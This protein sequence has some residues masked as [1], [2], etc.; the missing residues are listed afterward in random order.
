[1]LPDKVVWFVGVDVEFVLSCR[2]DP[3]GRY[4]DESEEET[5]DSVCVLDSKEECH[6]RQSHDVSVEVCRHCGNEKENGVL[7]HERLWQMCPSEVVVLAVEDLLCRAPLVVVQY[8][9]LVVQVPVV[10][11]YAAVCVLA[12]EE[13]ELLALLLAL[14]LYDEAAVLHVLEALEGERL[15]I[16][17][18]EANLYCSPARLLLHLLVQA[19]ISLGTYVELVSML[20]DHLHD[21]L[22]IGA[23]VGTETS[24]MNAERPHHLE[25]TA[26]G[27][28][29]HEAH[30]GVPP[31]V[32]LGLSTV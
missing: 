22:A 1:M 13:V 31:S 23:A 17:L 18:L 9:F 16:V 20:H 12:V 6:E 30:V 2:F 10:G 25:E 7:V 3:L 15:H 11:Q 8:D 29:L 14:P 24:D 4:G 27:L 28:C 5:L 19:F 21:V 26:V 32:L